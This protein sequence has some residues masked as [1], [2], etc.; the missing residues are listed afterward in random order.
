MHIQDSCK[1]TDEHQVR[2]AAPAAFRITGPVA[3]VPA[4]DSLTRYAEWTRILVPRAHEP[5]KK[6]ATFHMRR[7]GRTDGVA[8]G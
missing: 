1:V 3:C 2:N 7:K 4:I 8:A 5:S 6:P